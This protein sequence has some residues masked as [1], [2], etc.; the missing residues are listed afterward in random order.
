MC[1]LGKGRGVKKRKVLGLE[2]EGDYNFGRKL[3][4]IVSKVSRSVLKFGL[5][6][7]LYVVVF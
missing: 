4:K 1:F 3:F 6:F 2:N 7:V 5:G